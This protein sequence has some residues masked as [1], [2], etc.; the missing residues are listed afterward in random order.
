MI[1]DAARY[2][3]CE[4][5]QDKAQARVMMVGIEWG[6]GCEPWL[7][8]CFEETSD[9]CNI[10]RLLHERVQHRSALKITNNIV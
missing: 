3:R 4:S 5:T 8:Y 10:G 7:R 1:A 6:F 2:G 9:G